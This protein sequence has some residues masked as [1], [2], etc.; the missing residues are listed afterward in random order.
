[1]GCTVPGDHR[2]SAQLG[3][4]L[5]CIPRRCH[6]QACH[7]SAYH[8]TLHSSAAA[9]CLWWL[10]GAIADGFQWQAGSCASWT[11]AG[12]TAVGARALQRWS[13]GETSPGQGR[14]LWW[15]WG[16]A[17]SNQPQRNQ[18]NN[19]IAIVVLSHIKK[20]RKQ[21]RIRKDQCMTQLKC[22]FL[23]L[24]DSSCTQLQHSW[25]GTLAAPTHSR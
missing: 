7:L 10:L 9:L 14:V 17:E 8:L 25:S 3:A 15:G 16:G 12:R 5:P 21:Q 4:L 19:L 22:H 11:V 20:A 2:E 13:A 1:M 6:H 18:Q 23:T 24:H